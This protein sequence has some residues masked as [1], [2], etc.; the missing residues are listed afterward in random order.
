MHRRLISIPSSS[1]R[2]AVFLAHESCKLTGE[3][4]VSGGGQVMRLA[5]LENEGITSDELTPEVVAE[6]IDTIM[7]MSTAQ[8]IDAGVVFDG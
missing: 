8:R 7:D 2:A 4:L 6:N 3:V 5:L 1:R